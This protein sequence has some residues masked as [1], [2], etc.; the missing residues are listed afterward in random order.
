MLKTAFIFI[1]FIIFNFPAT[2]SQ[3]VFEIKNN[4]PSQNEIYYYGGSF[5]YTKNN[6]NLPVE[7][8]SSQSIP[9]VKLDWFSAENGIWYVKFSPVFKRTI[10]LY[11][12]DTLFIEILIPDTININALPGIIL[13]DFFGEKSTPVPLSDFIDS[14]ANKG[15]FSIISIPVTKFFN[16]PNFNPARVKYFY[17]QQNSL[18]NYRALIF[19]SSIKFT[20]DLINYDKK[21]IVVLG[22]S[23]AEGIGVQ[24]KSDSWV[25]MLEDT[26]TKIDSNIRVVNLA[27]GGYST[28]KAMPDYHINVKNRPKP[29]SSSNISKAIDF[30]SPVAIVV[31]FPTNDI[32]SGYPLDET[33]YNLLVLRSIAERN[34]AK[35]FLASP[36]PR[37]FTD[38]SKLAQLKL[39]VDEMNKIFGGRI[40]DFWTGLA[41]E[42]G[43]IIDRINSGD[44]I[45]LNELGHKILLNRFLL[46]ALPEIYGD[47]IAPYTEIVSGSEL[48]I[49]E[50]FSA[51][52]DSIALITGAKDEIITI[53]SD[54]DELRLNY[55]FENKNKTAGTEY[56][57]RFYFK[58]GFFVDSKKFKIPN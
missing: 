1:L 35:F 7:R 38:K 53:S 20:Y 8:A 3:V 12:C 22:S 43:W 54:Y 17:F 21:H 48:L 14:N 27:V 34:G 13:E 41:K 33:I 32:A 31:S 51:K 40:I 42:D 49:S 58:E 10:D 15:V 4:T 9:A 23:T 16:N 19:I 2:F 52:L 44:G 11:F 50:P 25:K 55:I 29:D 24:K 47:S 36:Q 57:Y 56:Y 37:N 46:Y 6:Q 18:S 5:I 30:Y 45:H 28:F 39:L 26:I